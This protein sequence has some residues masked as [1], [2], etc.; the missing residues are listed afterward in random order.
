[1]TAPKQAKRAA[2]AASGY[3]SKERKRHRTTNAAA[4]QST[5]KSS[6]TGRGS[7][8]AQLVTLLS[9]PEGA[10]IDDLT[11]KLGWLP[12]TVRAALTGLRRK[13]YDVSREKAE[14]G[15]TLYRA[16]PPAAEAAPALVSA[17]SPPKNKAAKA[18]L[19]KRAA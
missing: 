17:K 5:T 6:G 15:T 2:A 12:H 1:M 13:G 19:S 18:R 8:R 3:T 16:T 11:K 9:R 14:A 7:K 10:R 4:R